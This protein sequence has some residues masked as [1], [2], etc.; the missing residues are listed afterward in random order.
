MASSLIN[1]FAP[2][3]QTPYPFPLTAGTIFSPAGVQPIQ[4]ILQILQVV[5]Q[6]LQH[7]LQLEYAQQQQLQQLQQVLQFIP[8]QVM[9]VLQHAQ[10]FQQQPFAQLAGGV[11]SVNPWSVSSPL[12]GAQP[13]Y[14]M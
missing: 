11:P 12:F 1:P 10:H 13:S 2:Q 7:L 8:A 4:Q 9:Q 14:V 3:I 6:Q 5:P